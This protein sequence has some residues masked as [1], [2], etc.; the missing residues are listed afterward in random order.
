MIKWVRRIH[1]HLGV[2][3]APLLLFYVATGWYQT[4]TL[5]RNKTP[6]ELGD[7]PSRLRSVHVDQIYP[8]ETAAAYS[9]KLYRVL[10][11]AMCTA[12]IATVLLGVY[13]AFRVHRSPWPIV[14]SLMLGFAVPIAVLWLGQKRM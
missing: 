9:P 12:L 3:F 2:F 7:W 4:L 10:V 1:L 6:G 14:I 8:S 11:V 5:N 13:L